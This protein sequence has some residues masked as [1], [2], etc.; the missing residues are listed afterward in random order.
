MPR[1]AWAII[2]GMLSVAAAAQTPAPSWGQAGARGSAAPQ[3]P[4]AVNRNAMNPNTTATT[5]NQPP[6]DRDCSAIT[7]AD[8]PYDTERPT[9]FNSDGT[10]DHGQ[11]L[12]GIAGTTM[13]LRHDLTDLQVR[14][15]QLRCEDQNIKAKLDYLIRMRG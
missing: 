8:A 11:I 2:L 1:F 10:E 12:N 14:I 6:R 5:V 13:A 9:K 3:A 7:K 15:E 4:G